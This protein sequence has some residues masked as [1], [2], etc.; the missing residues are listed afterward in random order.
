MPW[1]VNAVASVVPEVVVGVAMVRREVVGKDGG[2]SSLEE[3]ST[4]GVERAR[5]RCKIGERVRL[6]NDDEELTR[7]LIP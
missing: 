5:S 2:S 4:E 3:S 7:C 1:N 6:K